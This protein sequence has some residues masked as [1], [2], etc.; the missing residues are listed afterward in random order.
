M[1]AVP[2]WIYDETVDSAAMLSGFLAYLARAT[3]SEADDRR[4]LA[5]VIHDST[6]GPPV[7]CA[8]L[9]QWACEAVNCRR[10]LT[11]TGG[12]QFRWYHARWYR[13]YRAVRL[14]GSWTID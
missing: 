1:A 10:C 13:G 14:P 8:G 9:P 11:G 3:R 7:S 12:Y 2:R 5:M 4:E 6:C